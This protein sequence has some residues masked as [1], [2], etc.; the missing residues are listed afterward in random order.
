METRIKYIIAKGE[1]KPS[2]RY[3]S[4]YGRNQ[5]WIR[6]IEYAQGYANRDSAKAS[7]KRNSL[8]GPDVYLLPVEIE[9]TGLTERLTVIRIIEP[10]G[11]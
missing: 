7:I 11:R 8:A 10:G 6:S 4:R 2:R 5:H 3:W 1:D 9:E